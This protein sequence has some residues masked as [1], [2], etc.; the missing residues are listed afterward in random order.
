MGWTWFFLSGTAYF[1]GAALLATAVV[2]PIGSRRSAW[3][4]GIIALVGLVV[5]ALSA[6]PLP[7]WLYA[8][9]F[10]SVMGAL[11]VAWVGAP[12]HRWMRRAA[13]LAA[14]L[15]TLV[16]I[17]VEAPYLRTPRAPTGDYGTMYEVGDSLSGGVG[18]SSEVTW[19]R[20][21]A[22]EHRI[23]VENLAVAGATTRAAL[24]QTVGVQAPRAIVVVEIGGNDLLSGRSAEDF[25]RDL[26]RLLRALQGPDRAIVVIELPLPPLANAYGAAQRR[27]ARLHRALL[28]P[29]RH[30]A[31]ILTTR[32]A[33]I[34]GLHMSNAGHRM[35]AEV[36]WDVVDR[37]FAR[38]TYR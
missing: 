26:D 7:L 20:V 15:L 27:Q 16:A 8:L 34:D 36:I 31:R 12:R 22:D 3:A 30:L 25:E 29:K 10:A 24:R 9:W 32:D 14:V 13:P 2:I 17:A 28:V 4:A 35:M 1:G 23:D 33:T 18:A 11:L 19:P 6:T 37:S 5:T 38:N 21:L